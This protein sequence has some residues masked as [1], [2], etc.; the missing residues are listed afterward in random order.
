MELKPAPAGWY[1]TNPTPVN[2][3]GYRYPGRYPV[4]RGVPL[5]FAANVRE[6][7][8]DGTASISRPYIRLD[9]QPEATRRAYAKG[10]GI[11]LGELGL[12]PE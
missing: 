2:L 10:Y 12:E 11:P 9:R 7:W 1:G 6:I 5:T 4:L 3:R 8:P